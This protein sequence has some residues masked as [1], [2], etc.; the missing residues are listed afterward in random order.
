MKRS[1]HPQLS[2]AVLVLVLFPLLESASATDVAQSPKP[3]YPFIACDVNTGEITKFNAAGEPVW[4]Y[5]AVRPIDAWPMP[6]GSVLVAYLP[7]PRTGNKGGVRLIGPAKQTLFDYPYND[8]IMSCQP[9]PNGNILV[10][11]GY[12]NSRVIEFSG[13]GEYVRHWGRKGTGDGEFA[14]ERGMRP[15]DMQ[16]HRLAGIGRRRAGHRGDVSAPYFAQPL[17]KVGL[18]LHQHAVK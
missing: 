10:S 12:V 4:V 8:E 6:D 16:R 5:S 14:I 1:F 11:D 9:L 7:S 17:G 18:R 13:D 15:Q 2:L 3:G